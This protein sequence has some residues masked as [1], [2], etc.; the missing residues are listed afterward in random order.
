MDYVSVKDV[1]LVRVGTWGA[2]TGAVSIT[3]SDLAAIVEAHNSHELDLAVIKKG[4]LDP[5]HE[6]PTWDGDPAY[7]QV[8]NLRL[9]EDGQTLLG[10]YTR[11]PSDLAESLPSAYP[12]RS[13]EIAWGVKLKD[14]AGKVR[15][16]FRAALSGLALLGRT[17]PAVKGLGR[18][19]ATSLSEALPASIEADAVGAFSSN[20]YDELST[21]MAAAVA[22]GVPGT[23]AEPDLSDCKL[24]GFDENTVY[25]ATSYGFFEAPYTV[26]TDGVVLMG[27]AVQV[28]DTPVVPPRHSAA[29][30]SDTA[31][32]KGDR[33]AAEPNK[34]EASM[35]EFHDKLRSKLGLPETATEEEI[36]AAANPAGTNLSEGAPGSI[37][38]SEAAFNEMQTNLSAATTELAD[39]RKE[40]EGDRRDGLIQTFL[41]E[42]RIHHSERDYWRGQLD[43]SEQPTVAFLSAR[44]PVVPVNELG[45]A[46]A[47]HTQLS[48]EMTDEAQKSAMASFGLGMEG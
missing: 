44:T 32:Q 15:K 12:H 25:I 23:V 26:D 2:S 46:A 45:H 7:G 22:A 13:V 28:A 30:D 17:P 20:D 14:P 10:D 18:Q 48:A 11:V 3:Q 34:E 8:D 42:G 16:T 47:P 24:S 9:S 35:A 31:H 37:V 39:I 19:M 36:L 43:S 33:P 5:R 1:P 6:N 27:D 4:H 40:R 21:T 38:V 29:T 41:S